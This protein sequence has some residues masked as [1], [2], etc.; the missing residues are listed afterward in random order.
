MVGKRVSY[1]FFFLEYC[2]VKL[3]MKNA[4]TPRVLIEKLFFLLLKQKHLLWN[5]N[6]TVSLKRFFSVPKT[7]V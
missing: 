7:H 5:L 1:A 4:A 2:T 6:R 3:M